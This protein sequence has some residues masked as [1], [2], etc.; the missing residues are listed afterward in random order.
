MEVG[1][2]ASGTIAE[3]RDL[4]KALNSVYE[5]AAGPIT[6]YRFTSVN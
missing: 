2:E 1:F 4:T 6:P 5:G 3:F